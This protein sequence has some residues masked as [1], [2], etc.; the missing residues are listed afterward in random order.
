LPAAERQQTVTANTHQAHRSV[1]LEI[2][3]SH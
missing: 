1:R 3:V 2:I